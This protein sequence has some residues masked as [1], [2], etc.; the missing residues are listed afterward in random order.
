MGLLPSV[1]PGR[2]L[3]EGII[4]W[5]YTS[6]AFYFRPHSTSWCTIS[7]NFFPRPSW[8]E[9][10]LSPWPASLNV[11][12]DFSHGW[13]VLLLGHQTQIVSGNEQ[14]KSS[15]DPCWPRFSPLL[16]VLA[17]SVILIGARVSSLPIRLLIMACLAV[18]PIPWRYCLKPS[19]NVVPFCRWQINCTKS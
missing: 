15:G 9:I 10:R 18:L 14:K 19:W 1:A 6:C 2:E 7:S 17:F 11:W 12:V 16:S 13:P 8:D 3:E 5:C 4:G